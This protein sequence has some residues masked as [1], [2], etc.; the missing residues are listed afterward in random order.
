MTHLGD[1]YWLGC[2][3]QCHSTIAIVSVRLWVWSTNL[4]TVLYCR[5]L[6]ACLT[7]NTGV[8]VALPGIACSAVPSYLSGLHAAALWREG[9]CMCVSTACWWPVCVCVGALFLH[10]MFHDSWGRVCCFPLGDVRV[11]SQVGFEPEGRGSYP[12]LCIDFRTLHCEYEPW[13]KQKNVF[14]Q[15]VAVVWIFSSYPHWSV[16]R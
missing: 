2:L 3:D 5:L 9:E 8:T 10:C 15:C 13:R 14:P 12:Y 1:Q 16:K 6:C 4:S 7:T 11:R